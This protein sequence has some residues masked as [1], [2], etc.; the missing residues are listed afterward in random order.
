MKNE[1][2]T[3]GKFTN[4]FEQNIRREI[5]NYLTGEKYE[6]LG[7]K[8]M[9]F[10]DEDI[11]KIV[12]ICNRPNTYDILFKKMCA[13]K[14]Y[15]EENAKAFTNYAKG[16]WEKQTNFVFIIRKADSEIIGA[17]DIKSP[18]T[19]RAEIGYWSDE[20]YS[21]F[22]TN[23]VNELLSLAKEGGFKKLF[24]GV[25]A[26]NSK[27]VGVLE[28]SGFIKTKEDIKDDEAHFEYEKPL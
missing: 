7:G 19:E 8:D 9:A 22:M 13:G 10:S 3:D 16:G 2:N 26:R 17:I 25:L 20:N 1:E 6:M 28:R 18:N 5:V 27:S 4:I 11:K 14:P 23:T 24:A 15:T 12:E 21:G